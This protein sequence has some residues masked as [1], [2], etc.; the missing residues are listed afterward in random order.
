M[1]GTYYYQEGFAL[2]ILTRFFMFLA[3]LLLS[4][5]LNYEGTCQ[6]AKTTSQ[7]MNWQLVHEQHFL[8]QKKLQYIVMRI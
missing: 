2:P 6:L 7:K 5:D 3:Q 1:L 8:P 4:H